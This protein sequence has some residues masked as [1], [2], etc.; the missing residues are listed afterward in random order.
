LKRRVGLRAGR[1]AG[2]EQ[3]ETGDQRRSV[4]RRS[5]VFYHSYDN[6]EKR[7]CRKAA[8]YQLKNN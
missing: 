7:A 5:T 1:V 6:R 8:M 3:A 2:D 4:T